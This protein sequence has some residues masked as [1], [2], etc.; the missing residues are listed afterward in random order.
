MSK[1]PR[2]FLFDCDMVTDRPKL[3]Q[4]KEEYALLKANR[5]RFSTEMEQSKHELEELENQIRR[6]SVAGVH[7][8][9][10]TP[11]EYRESPIPPIGSNRFSQTSLG[12]ISNANNSASRPMKPFHRSTLSGSQH[13]LGLFPPV[14]TSAQSSTLTSRGNSDE[15]EDDSY[16]LKNARRSAV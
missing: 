15:E 8:E 16:D 13:T 1:L 9:P 6:L 7:S 10:T 4:K 14:D 12:P 3:Q 5:D 2:D 11:P